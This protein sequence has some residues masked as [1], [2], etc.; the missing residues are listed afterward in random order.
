MPALRITHAAKQFSVEYRNDIN[1]GGQRS[2][3]FRN[4]RFNKWIFD[5]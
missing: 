5:Y 3:M 1:I 4:Q 2:A